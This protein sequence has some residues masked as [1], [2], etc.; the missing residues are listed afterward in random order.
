LLYRVLL[1]LLILRRTGLL[2]LRRRL[3]W[4]NAPLVLLDHRMLRAIVLLL[5]LAFP[6]PMFS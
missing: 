1:V 3:L 6:I 4:L 5:F 2:L